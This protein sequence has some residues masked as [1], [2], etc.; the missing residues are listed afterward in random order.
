VTGLGAE[1]FAIKDGGARQ[2]VVN[3]EPADDPMQIAVVVAG[4]PVEE[5]APLVTAVNA[6][7]S[8][9]HGLNPA[10][11]EVLVLAG[12]T[13]D[14]GG[15]PVPSGLRPTGTRVVFSGAQGVSDVLA[16]AV[17]DLQ[18]ASPNGRRLIVAFLHAPARD[19][20]GPVADLA[21]VIESTK[22][23]L[24][25]VELATARTT[26]AQAPTDPGGEALDRAVQAGG[27][28]RWQVD[29]PADLETGARGVAALLGTAQYVVTVDLPVLFNGPVPIATRHD[30]GIV[31]VPMW[32][33]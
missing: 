12:A 4:I 5:H 21:G 19:Q 27:G 1:D 29:T 15:G 8:V 6:L 30:R 7:I 18:S 16:A 31:L 9:V 17:R 26:G 23:S 2:P 24:W 32:S 13:G 33:R 11:R 28:L 14:W 22:T 3:S 10:S 25:T 20:A